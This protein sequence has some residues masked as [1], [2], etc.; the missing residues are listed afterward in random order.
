MQAS[1]VGR[2]D[3]LKAPTELGRLYDGPITASWY[4]Q[5]SG[6]AELCA[7]PLQILR[8]AEQ[9]RLAVGDRVMELL[10]RDIEGGERAFL[11]RATVETEQR[12]A[13]DIVRLGLHLVELF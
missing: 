2:R 8:N 10:E 1:W 5:R 13:Q 7:G 11:D 12:I 4:L 9:Q 6:G 3:A